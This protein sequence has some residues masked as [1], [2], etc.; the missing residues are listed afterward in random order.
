MTSICTNSIYNFNVIARIFEVIHKGTSVLTLTQNPNGS[1]NYQLK[2]QIDG[3]N[4]PNI[5]DVKGVG[6]L[7]N[8][9]FTSSYK[10]YILNYYMTKGVLDLSDIQQT[11]QLQ[12]TTN[13]I[14][15]TN[16]NSNQ[17]NQSGALM[18]DTNYSTYNNVYG[19]SKCCVCGGSSTGGSGGCGV[20]N[21][22]NLNNRND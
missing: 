16:S 19:G 12:G 8:Q 22:I 14:P 7:S 1:Y 11:F 10:G 2:T 3:L 13:P 15:E 18:T 21:I 9:I 5:F 17:S 6:F 20:T 4:C